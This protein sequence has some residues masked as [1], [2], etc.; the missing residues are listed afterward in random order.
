VKSISNIS[1]LLKKV[2]KRLGR[3]EVKGGATVVLALFAPQIVNIANLCDSR[4]II[5]KRNGNVCSMT[6]DHRP[7]E[8]SELDS[9][10]S[11]GTFLENGRLSSALVVSRALEDFSLNGVSQMPSTE[12]SKKVQQIKSK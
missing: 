3:A 11:S 1:T 8:R 9:L 5:V 10:R 4:A 6:T 12:K 7:T 2:N